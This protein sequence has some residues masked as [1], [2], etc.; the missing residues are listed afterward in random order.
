[1]EVAVGEVEVMVLDAVRPHPV[2][3]AASINLT[4]DRRSTG[5]V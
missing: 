5:R 2:A 4:A 3:A 1:V